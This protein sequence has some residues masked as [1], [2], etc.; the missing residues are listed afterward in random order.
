MFILEG[1]INHFGKISEANILLNFFLDSNFDKIS[2]MIHT[3]LFYSINKKKGLNFE[4]PYKFYKDSI[5]KV[6]KKKKKKLVYQFVILR[7]FINI[8]I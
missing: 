5:N 8:K 6:H 1:G 2:F 3:E 7:V 4:L